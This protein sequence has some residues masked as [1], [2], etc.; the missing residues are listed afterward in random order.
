MTK[1]VKFTLDGSEV[2]AAEGETI[3]QVARRL[4]IEIPHLCYSPEPGYRA[5]GNCRACMVE[6]E[7][8][9]ALAAS[10][11]RMPAPGMKVKTASERP[12]RARKL[13][14]EMLMADQPERSVAHDP[15]SKFWN[16]S[17]KIGVADSRF[18]ARE[19]EEADPSH[20][21]MAVNLDACIQ[22]N[23]CVRACREVQVNDVIGMAAV[24]YTH[25]TLP[26]KA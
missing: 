7:G 2:E 8:E 10:C 22:C 18:P 13:V 24:S 5:D 17:E 16:W 3:W 6:V 19:A 21:A 23:L 14:F 26:T 25:L 11:I 9:G 15:D 4:G 12:K 1:V 20:P